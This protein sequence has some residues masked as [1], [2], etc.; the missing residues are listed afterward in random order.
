MIGFTPIHSHLVEVG[1]QLK[2]QRVGG[3]QQQHVGIRTVEITPSGGDGEVV[4]GEV[5]L[6]RVGDV[7]REASQDGG[8]Q[9]WNTMEK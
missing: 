8:L 9:V 5:V 7:A 4:R 2:E 6:Q 3:L 1:A